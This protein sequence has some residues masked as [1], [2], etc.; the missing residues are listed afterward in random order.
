MVNKKKISIPSLIILI[1]AL[2]VGFYYFTKPTPEGKVR[3]YFTSGLDLYNQNRYE[4][5]IVQ[6]NNA[7]ALNPE[8]WR[9]YRGLGWS[10]YQLKDYGKA[11]ENFNKAIRIN[12]IDE[13]PYRGL[14]WVYYELKD[15]DKVTELSKKATG[16]SNWKVEDFGEN[17]E[18]LSS[19]GHAYL[20]T[21][22]NEKAKE[23]FD[24]AILLND[25]FY[26]TNYGLGRYYNNIGQFNLS[27]LYYNK[28][29]EIDPTKE[30]PYVGIGWLYLDHKDYNA[31]KKVFQKV[32]QINP[33]TKTCGL[34]LG[35]GLIE[36]NLDNIESAEEYLNKS[37][38]TDAYC[39]QWVID[40]IK[41][42]SKQS[43]LFSLKNFLEFYQQTSEI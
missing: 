10:Y 25:A 31:A 6:F 28:A 22:N 1:V 27:L 21:H 16:I 33:N 18:I 13:N 11:I 34:Y 30:E 14:G 3:E 17:Y 12:P 37:L 32:L 19:M 9:P 26:L 39:T 38:E 7:I 43:L 24:R 23:M 42:N 4:E 35:L 2:S 5:A 41:V 29:I 15:Y 20:K 40:S 36:Y 8:I